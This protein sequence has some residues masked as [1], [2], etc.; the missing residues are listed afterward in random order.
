MFVYF[1]TLPT[2]ISVFIPCPTEQRWDEYLVWVKQR[3]YASQH[4]LMTNAALGI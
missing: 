3:M 1:I 4:E 2:F